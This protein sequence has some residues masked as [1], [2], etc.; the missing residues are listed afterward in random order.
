MTSSQGM[1]S[2]NLAPLSASR[3]PSPQHRPPS[4]RRSVSPCKSLQCS[5]CQQSFH[6]A[7]L[8]PCYHTFCASCLENSCLQDTGAVPSVYCPVC[9]DETELTFRGVDGLPKNMYV[10][11]LLELQDISDRG[12][13]K[14]DLCIDNE[15][16]LSVCQVCQ[17]NLCEFCADAHSKTSRHKLIS[18]EDSPQSLLLQSTV[19][20]IKK[21]TVGSTPHC[22][23]H[24][25]HRLSLFCESCN[26][27]VCQMCSMKEHC[28]HKFVSVDGVNKQQEKILRTVLTQA[29]SRLV[30]LKDS[31]ENIRYLRESVNE[32]AQVVAEEICNNID[33]RMRALQEHKRTLLAQLDAIKTQKNNV[34]SQQLDKI[35]SSFDSAISL[36]HDANAA[37]KEGNTTSM[38]SAKQP[39]VA[40]LQSLVS[41]KYDL[42][43]KEDDY[44]QYNPNAAVSEVNGVEMFGALD[45]RGPSAANSIAEGEGL[46]EAYLGKVA[47]FR[48]IVNDRYKQRRESGKDIVKTKI[49][50]STGKEINASVRDLGSGMY[51]FSYIPETIGEYQISVLIQGKNVRSSP[52]T[53]N[54]LLRRSK[55]SGNFHCCSHCSSKGKKHVRC[56]CG[57]RMPGYSG[58][59]HAHPGHPGCHHW[60]C[61]GRTDPNS[62]CS[63]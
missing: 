60:S 4:R 53:V 39:V 14:C 43:P 61:C 45:S 18:A 33:E 8:L 40:K 58:C 25:A 28:G 26:V 38:F 36:N 44:I 51:A 55:H 48:A 54:V 16:A 19:N 17:Y 42:T 15:I 34:L 62:E 32:R 56:G 49:E 7:R 27:P 29:K 35:S 46:F 3:G 5:L 30:S 10:E 59:G 52:F 6:D 50:T 22:D 2:I 9:M 31:A 21:N 24:P 23:I 41:T 63:A 57:S 20:G 13:R 1:A 11:H 37:I 47:N 12:A